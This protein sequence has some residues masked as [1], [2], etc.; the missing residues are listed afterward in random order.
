MSARRFDP[1]PSALPNS[2]QNMP[3]A[4]R[5]EVEERDRETMTADPPMASITCA[6]LSDHSSR[7]LIIGNDGEHIADV[8]VHVGASRVSI[9]DETVAIASAIYWSWW[10]SRDLAKAVSP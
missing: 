2:E 3:P 7:V 6:L 4:I 1:S 5:F 8:R 10:R 9:S